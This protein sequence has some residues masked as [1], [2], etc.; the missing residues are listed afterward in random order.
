M[1]N[2]FFAL[3]MVLAASFSLVSCA[4]DRLAPVDN[5][6]GEG[7]PFEIST[8]ITKTTNDDLAT[9]WAKDDQIN[10][11]HAEAGTTISGTT[12]CVNDNAFTVD[13]GLSG[14]FTGTLTSALTDGKSYDWYANYPYVSQKTSPASTTAGYLTIGG[15]TQ[16]QTGNSSTAHLSGKAC[17]LYGV[18]KSVPSDEKPAL[19]MKNLASVVAIKVTNTLDD[20]LTVTSVAFTSTED[21]VGT[22]YINY[23]GDAPKYTKS[24]DTY[25]SSTA[26]LTVSGGTAIA[27][28]ES[29]TFYIAIKPHTVKSGSDLVISVNGISKTLTLTKDV[30]FT[31]GSIKTIGYKYEGAADGDLSG[32]Y[33]ILN[34]DKTKVCPAYTSGKNNIPAETYSETGVQTSW[35]MTIT[36]DVTTGLYTIQDANKLYLSATGKAATKQNYL[37]GISTKDDTS[38]W[39]ITI[40]SDGTASIVATKIDTK[41]ANTLRYNG[42]NNASVFSCYTSANASNYSAI[43]LV[44]YVAKTN[45]ATPD[46]DAE[47]Q[48]LNTIYVTWGAVTNAKDYT[49]TCTE[50]DATSPTSTQTVTGDECT[51]TGLKYATEYTVSVVANPTDSDAY[52]ASAAATKTLTTSNLPALATP[53]ISTEVQNLNSIKVSWA[54]ITGAKNY[55]VSYKKTSS[56]AAA[57]SVDVTKLEYI[58]SELE[59]GIS[60]TVSVVANPED[61][62][63]YSKSESATAEVTTGK[64]D[65]CAYILEPAASTNNAY[66]S[67]ADVEIDGIT[68][69]VTGNSKILPWRIG[70]KNITKTDRAIYSKTAISA[71]ITSI[72]ISHGEPETSNEITVNSMTLTVHN[73]ATD[74]A[75]GSN[76]VSTLS[77]TY[78]AGESVTFIADA[79]WTGKYYRIVYNVT[80]T[81]KDSKNKYVNKYLQ[82]TKAEFYK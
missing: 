64:P 3:G 35:V 56:T 33:L 62:T 76:A 27:K 12:N 71:K 10:L 39:S 52:Y 18:A 61:G 24:G 60:Y 69:N 5:A 79:D 45:L 40:N 54:A 38:L 41:Y 2:L 20:D 63:A 65:S 1:K 70:G 42:V 31:A 23:S 66:A 68:W 13:D 82:F 37:K 17:P 44:K 15:T 29:A 80:N 34:K 75:S 9:N 51:F 48:D 47:V 28:G 7:V 21:I 77:G 19:T 11:F 16:T 22:Y 78:K 74:A 72:I 43:E 4:E 81:S 55:T 30:T 58:I 57:T 53:V 6:A 59:Y 46:I 26:N 49:V 73:S 50:K 25:V 67:S 8:A 36:K 32:Q 14:K